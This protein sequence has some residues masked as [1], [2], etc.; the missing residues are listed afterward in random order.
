MR[1]FTAL[2]ASTATAAI[3]MVTSVAAADLPAGAS[4]LAGRPSYAF[5]VRPGPLYLLERSPY[6][7][8]PVTVI[9]NEP[10]RT[11]WSIAP[12]LDLMPL[13]KSKPSRLRG[14]YAHDR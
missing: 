1:S 5:V 10:G 3:M 8:Q 13:P 12:D 14:V 7:A 6:T 9:Y 11:P 4:G 2:L